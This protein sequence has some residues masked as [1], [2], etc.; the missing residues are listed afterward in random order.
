MVGTSGRTAERLGLVTASAVTLPA[1]AWVTM[2]GMASNIASMC[3]QEVVERGRRA[4]VRHDRHLDAGA[5][6][7]QLGRQ[8]ERAAGAAADAELQLVGILVG[9]VDQLAHALD[10]EVVA[11]DQDQRPGRHLGDGGELCEVERIVRVQRLGDQRAGR[12]EVE[13]IA[14]GRRAGSSRSA[15]MKLPPTL[16]STSTVV[17]MLSLIFC[18]ISRAMTSVAPPAAS[19][20]SS[21]IGLPENPAPARVAGLE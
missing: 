5:R 16:F 8:I 2:T 19:P 15:G 9:V 3:A 17:R 18:A 21:R 4:P 1:L 13:G 12:N 20:T 10:A 6:L 7:Q 14:V 11:R